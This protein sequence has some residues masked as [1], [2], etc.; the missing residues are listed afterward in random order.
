MDHIDTPHAVVMQGITK[1]FPGVTA[2]ENVTIEVERG[3][4]HAICGENGAGK[5]TLMKI[6]SGIYPPDEGLLLVN[7]VE[8]RL[9][10]I[11]I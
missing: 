7:G 3:K 11:H 10:L 8:V 6:L 1:R 5:S 4:L 2:L 9:S